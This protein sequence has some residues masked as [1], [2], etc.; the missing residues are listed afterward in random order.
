MKYIIENILLCQS[1]QEQSKSLLI[2]DSKVVNAHSRL[3]HYNYMR[4]NTDNFSITPGH[5]MID[6]SIINIDDF[7]C[8]KERMKHLQNIGCTTLI[9]ASDL[10]YE[11]QFE[12]EIKKAKH[13][14]INSSIDFLIGIKTP[15]KKLTATLVRKCNKYK[16]PVVF[17]EINSIEELYIPEWQRIRDE[18]F[19]FQI[20]ILPI[21]N[22]QASKMKLKK[23]KR[24][25]KELLTEYHITTYENAPDEHQPLSKEVL[26]NIGLYP[27]KGALL[28]GS[29]AD[30]LLFKNDNLNK[31]KNE[32]TQQLPDVVCANGVIKK[33]GVDIFIRPGSGKEIIVNVPRKFVRINQAFQP[34]TISIDY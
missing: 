31:D 28:T 33:A 12:F 5:V 6:L 2:E 34:T 26:S 30:Y 21:W 10:R 27:K 17:V 1:D 19:T 11:S 25:W 24:D 7:S 15:L 9:S 20:I 14:F 13:A 18:L 4:L 16:V 3:S 32:I 22:I 8:F 23:I 29:D